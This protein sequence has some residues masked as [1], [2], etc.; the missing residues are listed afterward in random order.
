MKPERIY[1]PLTRAEELKLLDAQGKRMRE[2]REYGLSIA[3][4]AGIIDENN[5]LT[6]YYKQ[7]D[8]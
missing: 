5:E 3:R 4:K 1:T 8:E 6:D 2:D 7:K